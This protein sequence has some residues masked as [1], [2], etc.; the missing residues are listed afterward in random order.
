MEIYEKSSSTG[1]NTRMVKT[2]WCFGMK[3]RVR[4]VAD[5]NNYGKCAEV[6]QPDTNVGLSLLVSGG[7]E[8]TRDQRCPELRHWHNTDFIGLMHRCFGECDTR[9]STGAFPSVGIISEKERTGYHS[10]QYKNACR[11]ARRMLKL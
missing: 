7:G 1:V 11:K 6:Y 4:E 8:Y 10:E 9:G 3:W 5:F 2:F